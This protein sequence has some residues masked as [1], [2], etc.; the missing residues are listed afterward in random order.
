MMFIFASNLVLVSDM[1][2][3]LM[4]RSH[5]DLVI[6]TLNDIIILLT[7]S[8]ISEKDKEKL[9]ELGKQHYHHGIKK[10]YFKVCSLLNYFFFKLKFL[11]FCFFP[12]VDI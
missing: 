1:I 3:N 2:D 12:Y 4:V 6:K 9:V 5:A 7:K 11:Y 10:E 8:F